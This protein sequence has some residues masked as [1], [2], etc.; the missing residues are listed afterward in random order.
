[1]DILALAPDLGG[2]LYTIASFVVALII[3]VAVHEYGHYIVGR[4][5][6]IKAEVFSLG[7]GPVLFSRVDKRGTRWQIAA[8]PLGGYVKFLGDSDAASG[9]D[10][11]AIGQLSENDRR[12]TMHGA[13]LWARAATVAA[14][15]IFNFILTIAI[16]TGVILWEG[17]TKEPLTIGHI[18]D[19]PA[20]ITLQSGDQIVS[21]GGITM[22][23]DGLNTIRAQIPVQA[24][25]EYEVLRDGQTVTA[26]GPHPY[27]PLVEQV[28]P[29]SAAYEA[30][31]RPGDVITAADGVPMYAFSQLIDV[32]KA[33]EGNPI[34][35]SVWR[36]GQDLT[37]DLS[38]KR[39]D[40]PSAE[41][42]FQTVW[43]I[44][45]VGGLFFDAAKEPVGVL[46]AIGAGA[47]QL[48]FLIEGSVSGLW[49]MITGAISTCNMSGPVGIAEVS[50]A[51]ASQGAQ[52]FIWFIGSLSAAVGL[53]NLFPV[54]VLD[55]G[56]L[57]FFAYEAV[58]GKPPSDKVL[59]ALM[60]GGLA[61]IL[62]LMVFALGN[63]LFCP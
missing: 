53:L 60:A 14:G 54:P 51:M 58:A 19:L 31:I 42:G 34:S 20:T 2:L 35:L 43:R 52:N 47:A 26:V 30:G 11:A 50:G 40:E 22:P 23:E 55:G 44:G 39:V 15:P 27:L 9:K 62:S 3:I 56:H 29:R 6:G 32:V 33:A 4:W 7:F 25:L 8:L 36:D 38:A 10:A 57:V 63:D 61:L 18:Q 41:G 5:G 17:Q 24:D 21:V 46:Q 59:R 13:P 37:I 1:M 12:H 45:V 16:F 28:S 48:W 49:H